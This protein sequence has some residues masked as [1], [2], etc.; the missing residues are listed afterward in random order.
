LL[1]SSKKKKKQ[2]PKIRWKG[3]KYT[4]VS[5]ISLS[6]NTNHIQSQFMVIEDWISTDV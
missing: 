2:R 4:L 5:C 1:F 6:W 3:Q